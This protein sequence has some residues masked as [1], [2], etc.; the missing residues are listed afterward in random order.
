ML[1]FIHKYLIINLEARG[2]SGH[3]QPLGDALQVA[4]VKCFI[5][6]LFSIRLSDILPGWPYRFLVYRF[7]GLDNWLNEVK[8]F[9][10]DKKQSDL[11][12]WYGYEI[13]NEP[14]DTWKDPNGLNFNDLW[15]NSY[16]DFKQNAPIEKITSPY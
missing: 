15:K 16:D 4:K 9:I 7:P 14:D 5:G 2:S 11:T 10:A 13:W 1:P 3:Q 12:N 8:S 6:V